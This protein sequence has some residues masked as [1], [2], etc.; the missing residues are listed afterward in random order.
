MIRE[1]WLISDGYKR[2]SIIA[3]QD[4]LSALRAKADISQEELSSIIGVSR[5]TYS[6]IESGKREMSWSTYLSLVFFFHEI[7]STKDMVDGINVFPTALFCK[8]NS[9]STSLISLMTEI[10]R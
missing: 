3:L 1:K 4:H 2:T 9:E 5:Q 7:K 6:A 8:F 10:M